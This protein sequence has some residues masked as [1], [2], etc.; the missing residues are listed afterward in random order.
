MSSNRHQLRLQRPIATLGL[1]ALI[2]AVLFAVAGLRAA[3]GLAKGSGCS[4]ATKAPAQLT[5][6][7]M[8]Q[9]TICLLNNLRQRHG[10][11]SL[12]SD[13]RLTRAAVAHSSDM[14]RRHYFSH[15]SPAGS[16][17]QT[18]IGGSGYL[19]GARSW[20]YGEI[21]G[22]GTAHGGSP[23]SIAQAWMHSPPHRANILDGS[24]HDFGV[25]VVHGFPGRGG[26]GATFTVDFG[27]R[28]G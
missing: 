1:S 22:G 16:T 19:R 23:K 21:I 3:P 11:G 5:E 13:R 14:V 4:G 27:G 18:R 15:D 8:R 10:L 6:G 28:S 7:Q 25:G 20:R 9:A 26:Q 2:V 24:F 12:H 17:V